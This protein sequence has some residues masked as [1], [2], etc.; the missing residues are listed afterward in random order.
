M[1]ALVA[2]PSCVVQESTNDWSVYVQAD[3]ERIA[4]IAPAVGL[5]DCHVVDESELAAVGVWRL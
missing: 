2:Y 5:A 4:E 3:P 1:R